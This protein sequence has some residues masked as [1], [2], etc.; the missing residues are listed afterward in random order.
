MHLD[1]RAVVRPRIVRHLRGY[2]RIRA[3]TERGRRG[4]FAAFSHA[5]AECAAEDGQVFVDRMPVRRNARL[6]VVPEPDQEWRSG[7]VRIARDSGD[8]GAWSQGPPPNVR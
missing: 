6:S 5:D 8:L 3:G 2:E 7:L 4:L 1:G